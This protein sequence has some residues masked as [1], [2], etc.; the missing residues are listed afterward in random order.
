M[1]MGM[2]GISELS[3]K[4]TM[5]SVISDCLRDDIVRGKLA[6]GTRLNL[7]KLGEGYSVGLI[8]LREALSRLSSTGFITVEDQRGFRVADVSVKEFLDGQWLRA[9]LEC[10]ALEQ[11]IANGDIAWEERLIAAHHRM[12]RAQQKASGDQALLGTEWEACHLNF[13]SQLLSGCQN[14]WLLQFIRTL[15]DHNARYRQLMIVTHQ[16][17]PRNVAQ[18]HLDL[19]NASIDRDTETACRLLREHFEA[20]TALVLHAMGEPTDLA[21]AREDG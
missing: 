17:F 18:E 20:T 4:R 8:P 9:R 14:S 3:A 16:P 5:A 10:M 11:S 13:H 21:G 7:R 19:L 1:D 15:F 12:T 6:P 2:A